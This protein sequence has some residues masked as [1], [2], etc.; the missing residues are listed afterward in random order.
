MVFPLLADAPRE[1]RRLSRRHPCRISKTMAL[2]LWPT[3]AIRLGHRLRTGPYAPDDDRR[4]SER[5]RT[6]HHAAESR[7]GELCCPRRRGVRGECRAMTFVV[8]A[9]GSASRADRGA[10]NCKP[11]RIRLVVQIAPDTRT[12]RRVHRSA[13][14]RRCVRSPLRRHRAGAG[15]R[16]LCDADVRC[17]TAVVSRASASVVRA[18]SC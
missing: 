1:R 14:S 9:A 3:A 2:L 4:R 15:D 17:R 8:R 16:R 13:K 10:T 5:R 12:S 6:D 11:G 18:R 7:R